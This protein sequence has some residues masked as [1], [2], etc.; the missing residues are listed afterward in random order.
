MNGK[1]TESTTEQINEI[2][3]AHGDYGTLVKPEDIKKIIHNV[4]EDISKISIETYKKHEAIPDVQKSELARYI[5][6]WKGDINGAWGT[7]GIG[8]GNRILYCYQR[9]YR[10]HEE[11]TNIR[12]TTS[13][14]D[15]SER[16]RFFWFRMLTGAG[17]A[18]IVLLTSYIAYY[19]I[20]VPLPFSRINIP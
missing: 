12:K 8:G 1:Y 19:V 17:I 2:L 9:M 6:E 20:E 16:W 13:D 11:I 3:K 15:K 10:I 14:L 4:I 5:N 7:S 18:A